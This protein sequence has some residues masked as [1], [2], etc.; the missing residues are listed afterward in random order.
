MDT[1][2]PVRPDRLV[3]T[4]HGLLVDIGFDSPKN[5]FTVETV[6][7]ARD[8][9]VSEVGSERPEAQ[10]YSA[11]DKSQVEEFLISQ[12]LTQQ[13]ELD[14][15]RKDALR[16]RT[17][18]FDSKGSVPELLAFE[19]EESHRVQQCGDGNFDSHRPDMKPDD[20]LFHEQPVISRTRDV[21]CTGPGI[22]TRGALWRDSPSPVVLFRGTK[23]APTVRRY[24]PIVFADEDEEH[25]DEPVLLRHPN[26][27]STPAHQPRGPVTADAN[28]L[29]QAH[30]SYDRD[31]NHG[32]YPQE[33]CMNKL[34][35]KGTASHAGPENQRLCGPFE[36]RTVD[37]KYN[38]E[39]ANAS[40]K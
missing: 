29:H 38:F 10:A 11:R 9:M 26:R 16:C 15:Y 31:G 12:L 5:E 40:T 21:H 25:Y 18:I 4:D 23:S 3:T 27:Q 24:S 19:S 17:S 22:P 37:S 1:P 13:R 28:S 34:V 20:V 36:S 30:D 6:R 8:K 32:T 33:L 35:G 39:I 2:A 7:P 14:A